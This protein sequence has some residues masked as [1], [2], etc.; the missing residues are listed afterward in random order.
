VIQRRFHTKDPRILG[1]TVDNFS[2]FGHLALGFL[3]SCVTELYLPD[4]NLRK[5]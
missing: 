4:R 2:F 1:V 3:Y 5:L